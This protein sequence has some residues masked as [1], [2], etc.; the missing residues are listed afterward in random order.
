MATKKSEP[1]S[2]YE[3]DCGGYRPPKPLTPPKADK[4]KGKKK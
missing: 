2:K 1:K 3:Y 4:G